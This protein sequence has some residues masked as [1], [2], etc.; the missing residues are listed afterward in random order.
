MLKIFQPLLK[1]ISAISFLAIA[2]SANA[3]FVQLVS[4]GAMSGPVTTLNFDSGVVN[5]A[6][7]S[8]EAG[9]AIVTTGFSTMHS[10]LFGLAEASPFTTGPD[11]LANFSTGVYQVGMYF[12]N[13]DRCCTSGFTATLSAYDSLD[14][15]IGAVSVVANMNDSADQFLGIQT[16]TLIFKTILDYGTANPSL[17][18]VID[19]FSYGGNSLGT[20][21]EPAS[22][23][24]LAFGLICVA[25]SRK[26]KS[27]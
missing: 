8:F 9:A 13:D 15:L 14:N 27:A 6:N 18:G 21:P 25:A 24:L 20:V 16:D 22:F 26:R 11:N 1:A 7:M 2:G 3:A 12:G 23:A 17:W 5:G 4:P 19:D 10:G